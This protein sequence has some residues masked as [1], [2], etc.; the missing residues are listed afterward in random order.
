MLNKYIIALV[1]AQC[2]I[3]ASARPAESRAR[4]K[5]SALPAVCSV[6]V[7]PIESPAPLSLP[8]SPVERAVVRARAVGPATYTP[9]P[10]IGGGGSQF[11]D[12]AHF[13]I[14]GSSD[15]TAATTLQHLEA[16]HA[17]FVES[18][19]WATPA[20]GWPSKA[21]KNYYKTNVYSRTSAQLPGAA[22][23]MGADGG[24]GLA[25][26]EVVD[27]YLTNPSVTVHE[28][29]HA[30]TYAERNW[31]DQGRT[32]AWWEPIA[33]L[34]ADIYISTP[35]CSAAK[36]AQ[37]LSS[38]AGASIIDLQTVISRSYQVLVDGTPDSG[39]VR[40][41]LSAAFYRYG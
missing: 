8:P 35:T 11:K 38:G 16:A 32:G 33:N 18:L 41:T 28:Y 25:W 9:N 34:V 1:A 24:P 2:S 5:L 14:Y 19:G 15:S 10:N 30:L 7:A 39:N 23:V 36:A 17:C 21:D 27:D 13:R 3:L 26:L 22:G 29:G 37:G 4:S 31:I 40:D 20:Q 6:S 12:S